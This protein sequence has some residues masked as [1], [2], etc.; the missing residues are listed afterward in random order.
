[1]NTADQTTAVRQVIATGVHTVARHGFGVRAAVIAIG[2]GVGLAMAAGVT[3]AQADV[4]RDVLGFNPFSKGSSSGGLRSGVYVDEAGEEIDCP[5]VDV[6]EGGSSVRRGEG[7]GLSY[8]MTIGNLARECERTQDQRIVVN[9]GVDVRALIGPA[10]RPG[11]FS[12]P[13][14]IQIKRGD[15]VLSRVTRQVSV[16]IPVGE[17]NAM[18]EL[19]ER[20]IAL[21]EDTRDL[22]IEVGFGGA[23]PKARQR[24][25]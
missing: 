14:T 13:M 12:S 16:T 5:R 17:G 11:R 15:T 19:V 7:S 8:Q 6:L 10:G 21:P 20:G 9:V 2:A 25:R 23:A 18:G 4:L 3:P 22:L 24:G 1:M